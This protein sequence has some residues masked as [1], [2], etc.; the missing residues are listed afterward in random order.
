MVMSSTKRRREYG[1]M[2]VIAVAIVVAIATYLA[3]SALS[4][5]TTPM[6]E[7]A[8]KPADAP[9]VA[10][11]AR[12]AILD[13]DVVVLGEIAASEPG[14][15]VGPEGEPGVAYIQTTLVVTDVLGRHS[16][17]VDVSVGD[18]VLVETELVGDYRSEG[19]KGTVVLAALWMKRDD[20]SVGTYFR[21]VSRG[22]WLNLNESKAE[23]TLPVDR[24]DPVATEM[25]QLGLSGVRSIADSR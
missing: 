16:D 11:A 5:P 4:R 23:L 19:D 20:A 24:D 15:V 12:E 21:P 10:Y 14:R 3:S 9:G 22:A 18:S 1:L 25:I 17:F 6:P 8:G 2:G 13:A 7:Y